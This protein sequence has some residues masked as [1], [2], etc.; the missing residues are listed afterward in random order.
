ML[1]IQNNPSVILPKVCN[2]TA[3]FTQGSLWIVRLSN[4][5]INLS[6]IL[7]QKESAIGTLFF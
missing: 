7:N 6:F 4:C 2:M 5:S 1:Q 3:P